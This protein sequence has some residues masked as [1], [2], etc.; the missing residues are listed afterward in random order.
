MKYISEGL[1][2]SDNKVTD[3]SII[4]PIPYHK[5]AF[6]RLNLSEADESWKIQLDTKSNWISVGVCIKELVVKNNYKF[7]NSLSDP[8]FPL[9]FFGLSSNGFTWNKNVP[10][11][12]SKKKEGLKLSGSQ[13]IKVFYDASNLTLTFKV[14]NCS[15]TLTKVFADDNTQ[16]VPCV[17]FSKNGDS[18]A[19]FKS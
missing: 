6:I 5:F 7:T 4:K 2:V 12:N 11:E 13:V 3:K 10:A 14:D 1:E 18:A 17:I 19:Y 15:F 16:M 8:K 9:S